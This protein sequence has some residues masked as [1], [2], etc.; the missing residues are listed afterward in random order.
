MVIYLLDSNEKPEFNPSE[1]KF[2]SRVQLFVQLFVQFSRPES[3][4]P[5]KFKQ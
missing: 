5:L 4:G 2:L 3:R 1:W